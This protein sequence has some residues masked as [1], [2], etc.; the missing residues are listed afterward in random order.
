M[1]DVFNRD[2]LEILPFGIGYLKPLVNSRNEA[3]DY[4]FIEINAFFEALSNLNR[5]DILGMPA[6]RA[7]RNLTGAGFDWVS[8]FNGVLRTG[9]KQEATQWIESLRGNLNIT[10]VPSERKFL[11]LV[12]R[13]VAGRSPLPQQSRFIDRPVQQALY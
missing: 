7:F 5:K 13:D 11:A 8:Y 1:T 10:A 9:R 2:M 4:T 3:E 12:I 6:S